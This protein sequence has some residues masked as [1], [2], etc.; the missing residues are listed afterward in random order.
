MRLQ[1]RVALVTG[2]A[3]G[4]GAEIARVFS[5]EGASLGVGDINERECLQVE[6]ELKRAG[7]DARFLHETR[8]IRYLREVW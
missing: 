3:Q 4:I 2:A 8:E 5:A 1:G 7:G 6:A